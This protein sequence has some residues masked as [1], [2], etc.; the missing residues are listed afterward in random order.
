MGVEDVLKR[1]T[2]QQRARAADGL[3]EKLD[4]LKVQYEGPDGEVP[5][6]KILQLYKSK[7]AVL[8]ELMQYRKMLDYAKWYGEKKRSGE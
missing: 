5:R 2:S 7:F 8:A 6:P 4:F 3:M 1:M